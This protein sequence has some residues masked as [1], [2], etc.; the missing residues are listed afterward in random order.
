MNGVSQALVSVYN[1]GKTISR[2]ELIPF[3][4]LQSVIIKDNKNKTEQSHID[5]KN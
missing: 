3:L 5:F 2:G 1:G 4:R